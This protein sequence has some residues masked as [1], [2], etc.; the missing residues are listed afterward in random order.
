MLSKKIPNLKY[1]K[2]YWLS[3]EDFKCHKKRIAKTA[4]QKYLHRL[5]TALHA[6]RYKNVQIN[7]SSNFT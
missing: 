5:N 7:H 3:R 6:E 1:N 4:E 2:K